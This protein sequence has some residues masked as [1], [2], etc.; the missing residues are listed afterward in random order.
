MRFRV[1]LTSCNFLS[2][3]TSRISNSLCFL[4]PLLYGF[5]VFISFHRSGPAT[6]RVD[7]DYTSV[8]REGPSAGPGGAAQLTPFINPNDHSGKHTRDESGTEMGLMSDTTPHKYENLRSPAPVVGATGNRGT[9]TG[10]QIGLA[11]QYHQPYSPDGVGGYG[12]FNA[13]G[14]VASAH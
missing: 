3:L 8:V 9:Q 5:Y 2:L 6:S 13:A 10:N 11:G 4:A 14:G 1:S 12:G 7:R